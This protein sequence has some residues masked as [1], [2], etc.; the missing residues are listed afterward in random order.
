MSQVAIMAGA[1]IVIII[2][3]LFLVLKKDEDDDEP[4]PTPT[5][6]TAPRSSGVTGSSDW[7]QQ[8]IRAVTD[9]L[10]SG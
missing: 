4:S 9:G 10:G 8:A 7:E 6:N 5:V 3:I 1:A 2:I